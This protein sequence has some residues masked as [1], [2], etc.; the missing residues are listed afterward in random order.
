MPL[1]VRYPRL[2]A[3]GS[4]VGRAG[5]QRRLRP[6]LPRPR[7]RARAA[8]GCRAARCVPLL[9]RGRP[10][11][12]RLARDRRTTATGST[13][14]AATAS[15]PT[16]GSARATA[17]SSTTTAP[18]AASRGPPTSTTAAGVGAVRPRARPRA[19][20]TA[21][22]TTRRTPTTWPRLRAELDRLAAEL[23]DTVPGPSHPETRRRAREHRRP[24]RLGEPDRHPERHR[25][26]L[27]GRRPASWTR[28]TG[29]IADAGA[30]PGDA[31]LGR[32]CR[33]PSATRCTSP[34][35]AD[36]TFAAARPRRPRRHLGPA[37]AVRRHDRHPGAERWYAVSSLS[38]V[39]VDGPHVRR[40]SS[41]TPSTGAAGAVDGD[42]S[43]PARTSGSCRGPWRPMIGSEHLS[44]A[45][46]D[47]RDRRPGGRR[48]AVGGAGGRPRRARR[49]P[50]PGPRDPL[51]RPRG[52]PRG[53]RR[54]G[55]RLHRRGPGLRP[56]PVAGAVSRSSSCRSC[57]T[58]WPAT[59]PRRSS[60]TTRSCRRPRT[61][62]RW[63][64]LVR[65]LTAHL[66]ERYGDEVVEHWSFE[67]WNEANLEVF[68]SG[69]PED[70]L[71]LY[72][73][74]AAAVRDVD[75]RLV[76]G[77]PSSAAA[78]WCEELLAHA[79]RSGARSTSSPRTPT[80]RRRWT[81]GR[82]WSATAGAGTPIWWTEWGVTP[83]HFN[84]VSDAVFSGRVPGPR[85]A[86][87]DGPDRGAVLL[88]GLRPLRGAR[89]AA[90]AAARRLRAAD[91]R[92]AA[93]AAWWALA[94]LERLGRPG[95]PVAYDGD[96]GGLA[97]RGASP[98]A[99]T[100]APHAVAAVEPHPR[101]DQG[102]R[103]PT[104]WPARSTSR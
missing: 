70:Y 36:G 50:R 24:H 19:S 84:E 16:A 17:S 22:T 29:L 13:S 93:Q 40:R 67:V 79:E 65:D 91:R 56:H 2:V 88:G 45:L 31:H 86:V 89:P 46:L 78:G 60:T 74:T 97:G 77:G 61:G 85:D 62:S 3:P 102:G 11:G 66:V 63:Y 95:S 55:P 68:W 14:T 25:D 69:T 83:T 8:S 42:A 57:R 64:D 38:D 103:A 26:G 52:L 33:A 48:G 75:D 18:A 15:P 32:R 37:P 20:C 100:T 76:V 58:T 10:G 12:G 59:R 4:R 96:G 73:V 92:R 104:H 81:S 80:A 54:A 23:G 7:R 98:P 82:C 47:R 21:S 43:T 90:G 1:L 99:P 34:T 35:R 44:H 53:G 41:A 30:R 9:T 87:G 39:H 101:P 94:M 51:R 6:D 28:P 27:R 71:K 72:D 49:Q 5:A